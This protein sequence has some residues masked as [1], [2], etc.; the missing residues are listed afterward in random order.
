[1]RNGRRPWKR[2]QNH[3]RRRAGGRNSNP[4]V[5]DSFLINDERL[6][7]RRRGGGVMSL[8]RHM[9]ACHRRTGAPYVWIDAAAHH[10]PAHH[11]QDDKN[12]SRGRRTREAAWGTTHVP[13]QSTP[14]TRARET[15]DTSGR[16]E[17]RRR[18]RSIFRKMHG[19]LCTTR[20]DSEVYRVPPVQCDPPRS[21]CIWDNGGGLR[22]R[23]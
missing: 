6:V 21:R 15:G 7:R 17:R 20:G 4:N 23:E 13:L 9:P 22:M 10:L 14:R 19:C 2:N 18:T 16:S 8:S 11:A 1:M 3:W 12:A 5:Q